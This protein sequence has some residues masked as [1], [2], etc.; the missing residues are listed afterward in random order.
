LVFTGVVVVDVV[1][2]HLIHGQVVVISGNRVQSI[3]PAGKVHIPAGAR[4]V[5]AKNKYM[6]PGLWDMH[7]HIDDKAEQL[8]PLYIAHGITGLREMA[9][10]FEFGADS[11]RVWQSEVMTGT[12]VGPRVFGPS[13]DYPY[14]F[15]GDNG[16]T[17]EVVLHNID[18]LKKAGMTF[19][20]YHYDEGDR[21]SFFAMAREARR[22]G[23]PM[24][25]H[26]PIVVTNV[27]AADS[28]MVSIEHINEYR[29]CWPNYSQPLG[30]S[31]I[32]EKRCAPEI[33]AYIRNSTWLVP[34]I[35]TF[36]GPPP[37]NRVSASAFKDALRV[38][39][40]MHRSGVT[41]FLAG[42]DWSDRA[43]TFGGTQF[44]PGLSAA[45]EVVF[46]GD[47][48][49]TALE[50]LQ[51]GTLN[52]AKFFHATDS[53]GT[54]KAG[55]LAD[56]VLLDSNPL[57][58]IH[59]VLK[60]WAVVANGR[61]FNRATL[62]SLDPRGTRAGVGLV[63]MWQRRERWYSPNFIASTDTTEAE[64]TDALLVHY[65]ALR[66]DLTTFWSQHAALHD[67]AQSYEDYPIV[68][69]AGASPTD[70]L[71]TQVP[72]F[73]YVALA[74]IDSALAGVF[75]KNDFPPER[76]WP[77]QITLVKNM[78]RLSLNNTA[79]QSNN[80]ALDHKASVVA[81]NMML[82]EAHRS[83]LDITALG[84]WHPLWGVSKNT[85]P[86]TQ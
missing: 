66:K 21:D 81:K 31:A 38:V 1:D 43:K 11:F 71:Y 3:G 84:Q 33:Q 37:A 44:L 77:V 55:K 35:V 13:A 57:A 4:V 63:P 60:V 17:M 5:D 16:S 67:S 19:L 34:T 23:L 53:L 52:P 65:V 59:N 26:V 54:L 9:Q 39:R 36:W 29:Q 62:D 12:R 22:V 15:Q 32:A 40:M 41:K 14:H 49:F 61:Y 83:D 70:G 8:Y 42:S 45:E 86:P 6:I 27:E 68:G 46:F 10:R 75:K 64:L 18:S 79:D 20:K 25:G 7:A 58:N 48:G 74:A 72:I 2:G 80:V 85:K 24:V 56:L 76:Y 69:V 30:D 51:T 73:D 82:V 50:A 78:L 47:A 28:G